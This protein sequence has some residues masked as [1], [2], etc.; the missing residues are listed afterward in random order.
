VRLLSILKQTITG[1]LNER[2]AAEDYQLSLQL[3]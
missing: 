3:V 2:L 1:D